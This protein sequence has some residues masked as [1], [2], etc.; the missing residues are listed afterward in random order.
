MKR[1]SDEVLEKDGY[2]IINAEDNV[3]ETMIGTLASIVSKSNIYREG[4]VVISMADTIDG[5]IK[6]SLR[7]VGINPD[8]DLREIIQEAAKKIGVEESGGHKQ[9]CGCLLPHEKEEEFV[10]TIEE[11]LKNTVEQ[12]TKKY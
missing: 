8:I 9:A 2:V 7:L 1:G 6:V 10:K 3:K 4:T 12:S 5:N 11:I